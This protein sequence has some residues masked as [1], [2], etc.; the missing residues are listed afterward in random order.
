M[1]AWGTGLYQN[2]DALDLRDEWRAHLR[3]GYSP[4]EATKRLVSQM[5]PVADG[6]EDQTVVPLILADLQWRAGALEPDVRRR[7]LAI[8]GRGIDLRRWPDDATREQRR[9]ALDQLARRLRS[10][11]PAPRR[12]RPSHPCDWKPGE[13]IVWRIANGGYA[14]LRV[15]GFNS[16]WGGGGSPVV[17]LV[18]VGAPEQ[19]LEVGALTHAR[20]RPS[21]R[22]LTTDDGKRWRGTRFMIGVLAPDTYRGR[23]L[24]R[25]PPSGRAQRLP[26]VSGDVV[27]IG[28]HDLDHF[29]F[30]GFDVPWPQGT[31]FR[32]PTSSGVAFVVVV[33][34]SS[35]RSE[36]RTICEILDW[37]GAG[38]PSVEALARLD[39]HRT[40]DTVRIVR[41][42]VLDPAARK[43]IAAMKRHLGVRGI[44]ERAPL[45]VSLV[46]PPPPDVRAVGKRRGT[47]AESSW[48]NGHDWSELGDVLAAFK[49]LNL[50]LP[51]A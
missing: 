13:H 8:I 21:K 10:R 29:L 37:R 44:D 11:M 45:R 5:G 49:G 48:Y 3:I 6:D 31:I 51:P 22:V 43:S 36:P 26:R 24:R 1:G 39:V 32:V 17:E 2:D 34:V 16:R 27:G 9:R 28:W 42:R 41:A 38:E 19:K 14:V 50:R 23:R 7:A 30:T 15:V 20:T 4:A 35:Y 25:L 46:G 18:D 33:D 40:G 47:L 12:T